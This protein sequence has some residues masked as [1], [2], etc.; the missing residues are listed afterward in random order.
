MSSSIPPHCPASHKP[1]PS[2][3][4]G[5]MEE[6]SQLWEWVGLAF[7]PWGLCHP[8]LGTLGTHQQLLLGVGGRKTSGKQNS[9]NSKSER[10]QQRVRGTGGPGV[11][12]V[13]HNMLSVPKNPIYS[14]VTSVLLSIGLC[15]GFSRAREWLH[16]P[17]AESP[18]SPAAQGRSNSSRPSS[19]HR[20]RTKV[21]VQKTGK[22]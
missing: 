10:L 11:G 22:N 20:L 4:P 8:G 2:V 12:E 9:S 15:L 19:K 3:E 16:C 5:G 17:A 1:N 14:I 7:P 13:S 21:L 6:D 18:F